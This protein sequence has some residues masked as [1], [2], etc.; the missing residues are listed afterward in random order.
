MSQV[1]VLTLWVLW[2]I[3]ILKEEKIQKVKNTEEGNRRDGSWFLQKN[4]T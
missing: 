3:P 2:Q 4:L 1:K